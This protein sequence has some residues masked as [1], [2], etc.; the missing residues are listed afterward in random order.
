MAMITFFV[1]LWI[2]VFRD[3]WCRWIDIYLFLMVSFV[4]MCGLVVD[5]MRL[6]FWESVLA[7]VYVCRFSVFVR[8]CFVLCVLCFHFLCFCMFSWR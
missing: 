4:Y 3:W 1:F 7:G 8:V 2:F 6:C 5:W